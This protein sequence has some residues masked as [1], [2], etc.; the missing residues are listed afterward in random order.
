M[1]GREKQGDEGGKGGGRR[2][3]S[4]REVSSRK[5]ERES[6]KEKSDK[7]EIGGE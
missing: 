4:L 6:L 2:W 1:R 3:E 7:G 5:R